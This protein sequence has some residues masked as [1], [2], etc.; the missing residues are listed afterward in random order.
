MPKCTADQMW[1][2]RLGRREIEADFEGGALSSDGGLMLL[3][4]VD[5][6]IGLSKAVA[7]A[8]HDP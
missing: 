4:Q 6:R 2:G 3:R 5:R 8:L 1:F 7:G